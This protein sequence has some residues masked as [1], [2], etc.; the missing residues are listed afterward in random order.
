[1]RLIL[2]SILTII[3]VISSNAQEYYKSVEARYGYG[4]LLAHR[5]NMRH[6]VKGHASMFEINVNTNRH[7]EDHL[8]EFYKGTKTGFSLA[9]VDAGNKDQ[10]GFSIGAY[11]HIK[12]R[13]GTGKHAPKMQLG[14][15]IG[16]V[17]KPFDQ[18]TNDQNVAVGSY[19]NAIINFSLED[20]FTINQHIIKYGF[21]F[22]HFSNGA[23][24]APNLGLNVPVFFLGYGIG[25]REVGSSMR[26]W[27]SFQ[28]DNYEWAR[29]HEMYGVFGLRE[30][31]LHSP[32][33]YLVGS[34]TYQYLH[35]FSNKLAW[36]AGADIF[37][38]KSLGAEFKGEIPRGIN[39][40]VGGYAGLE[41]IFNKSSLF[42][43]QGVYAISRHKGN[44]PVYNRVGY[45]NR[46]ENGVI[47]NIS[48][49]THFAIA[50][51]FEFGIGYRFRAKPKKN[52]EEE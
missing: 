5:S 14:A 10:I 41:V 17:Q 12:F 15:G 42:V 46:F 18:Q 36:T 39:F 2:I 49:K 35:Q 33:Q 8:S 19:L 37:H 13:L 44:G 30:V 29:N 34:I 4:F 32:G 20:Q 25:L 11:P 1:M 40:Q 27:D 28:P 50:E 21:S 45:R 23:Y 38:N 52:A 48:L 47:L 6:L 43:E 24:S 51:Y 3:L 9:Y 7:S 22:T 16:F 26:K 31:N